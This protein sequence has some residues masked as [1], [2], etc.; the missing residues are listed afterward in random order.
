MANIFISHQYTKEDKV[1]LTELLTKVV[2]TL[3]SDG[4]QVFCST[5]RQEEFAAK[6]LTLYEDKLAYC[7]EQQTTADYV[8][9]LL[10]SENLSVGMERELE[11]AKTVGQKYLLFIKQSL[12]F[13][14]YRENSDQ[15]VEYKD[16][17]ELPA[18]IGMFCALDGQEF[19]QGFEL[20]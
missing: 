2:N 3:V 12:G 1:L 6:G 13:E 19:S 9:A 20:L 4:H 15:I 5:L 10:M 8:I 7:V 14:K 17:D 18:L 11:H 16:N